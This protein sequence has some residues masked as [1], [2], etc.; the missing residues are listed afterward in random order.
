MFG[1]VSNLESNRQRERLDL[2]SKM[3]AI[4][5]SQAVIEFNLDGTIIE[6]NENFL[7]TMGYSAAEIVGRHHSIFM[8]QTEAASDAYRAFWQDLRDGRFAAQK[9]R[10]LG[11][12]GREV[13]IQ[14][15]YNPIIDATGK[16]YKV[17]KLAVDITA[18][19]QEAARS[20][21]ARRHAEDIQNELVQTLAGNLSRLSEGDLTTRIE[22]ERVGSHK[23][24]QEDF[25]SAIESLRVTLEEV[26]QS[27]GSI[28]SSSDEIAGASDDLSRRTE[29]QAASLEQ[30]A[31]ALDQIT[32]TVKRSAAGAQ[33]AARVA[34]GTRA[35]AEQSGHVVREAVAAMDEIQQSSNEIGQII[36][37][38]D[39]IAFQT[40]LLALNA[41]VEAARAGDAGR[42]FAVVA[43]E[44]RALAQRSAA[45]AK[46]IKS[47]IST[48]TTQV[49]KGVKLV[50]DT[51]AALTT[52]ATRVAEI[53]SL[54]VEIA[55]SA[56]EQSTALAQI[57]SAING[58]DQVTQQNAAMVE[59]A[60]AAASTLQS[61]A[62]QLA[63]LV[64]RFNTA[65]PN[66]AVAQNLNP[67]RSAQARIEAF[68]RSS[69]LT[70]PLTRTAAPIV[71]NVAL[72]DSEWESF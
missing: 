26:L 23:T 13:W 63:N 35:D 71:G 27:V 16:P 46:E 64:Q 34:T 38:I 37:V 12:G 62:R 45:A 66:A 59:Q 72:K 19:E 20:N 50:D 51:G 44:V 17:I 4:S 43:Q 24:V 61:E 32:A 42:G 1:R 28:R 48:S 31:A 7:T 47:L 21:Q 57:N 54:I 53:D 11:K 68:A 39:E 15:S 67:V 55:G 40:N 22:G 52:I 30:T 25:N 56:Q 3:E 14:A 29:Q 49:A 8:D 2:Q 18:A 60:T 58:M 9:F 65:S 6:A 33:Q 10:R 41:G 69:R 70:P 5:R 36:G